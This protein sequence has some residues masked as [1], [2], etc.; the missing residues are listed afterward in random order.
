MQYIAHYLSSIGTVTLAA[1]DIG[2]TGLWLDS[3]PH[4]AIGKE[5]ETPVLA[6]SKLWLDSYFSGQ[7][8]EHTPPLH[9]MG[10]AFQLQVW[11]M[12]LNIP[13]GQTVTYGDIAKQLAAE[14]GKAKMSA[15][16]VGGAVVRNPVSII[17]PCHRVLGA[18]GALT[19]YTGGLDKKIALLRIEGNNIFNGKLV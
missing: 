2:L 8:P 7:E 18:N 9:L 5:T 1:D 3:Q 13:Y 19:G 12:L 17:V 11:A 16:A 15:Q 6:Q 14:L 4:S 10:T